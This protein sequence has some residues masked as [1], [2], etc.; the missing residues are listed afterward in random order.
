MRFSGYLFL[1][2]MSFGFEKS[3]YWEKSWININRDLM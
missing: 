3:N 1:I 2:N